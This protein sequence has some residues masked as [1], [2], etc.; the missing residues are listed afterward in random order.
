MFVKFTRLKLGSNSVIV[1]YVSGEKLLI[2]EARVRHIEKLSPAEAWSRY[3][4]RIFLTEE[5]YAKYARVSPVSNEDR[6]MDE[7]TV[8][9]LGNIRRYERPVRS[10]YPV[11]SSGRYLSRK[12]ICRIRRLGSG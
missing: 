7:I 11:T 8:F 1:F 10:I 4:N 2:G 9:E 12:M 3:R 5:E 6:K